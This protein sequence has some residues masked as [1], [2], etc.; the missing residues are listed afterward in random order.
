MEK[1][2]RAGPRAEF[3]VSLGKKNEPHITETHKKILKT[4]TKI[5]CRKRRTKKNYPRS[6]SKVR[7]K[8]DLMT[9][10]RGGTGAGELRAKE[11]V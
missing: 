7:M 11:Q 10:R 6:S 5:S 1:L 4:T 2:L 9:V 8:Y 3:K